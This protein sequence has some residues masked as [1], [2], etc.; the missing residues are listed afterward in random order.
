MTQEGQQRLGLG[1][2]RRVA[3]IYAAQQCREVVTM[4]CLE[5]VCLGA[6]P[7]LAIEPMCLSFHIYS[8]GKGTSDFITEDC[9]GSFHGKM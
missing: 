8:V 5:C 6:N 1:Y 9:P 3:G 2:L 4:K 7:S